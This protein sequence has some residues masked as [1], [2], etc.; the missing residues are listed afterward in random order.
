V[1]LQGAP[2]GTAYFIEDITAQKR[3]EANLVSTR[4]LADL[5]TLT[6]G[7]V[8]ELKSP[9]QVITGQSESLLNRLKRGEP[10]DAERLTRGLEM[11]N[12]NGWRIADTIRSMLDYARTSS[13]PMEPSNLN[14]L[15]RD[16]LLLVEHEL[17]TRANI[18]I[19]TDL[20]PDLPVWPC[21]RNQIIQALIN[22]LM[23]AQDAMSAG[24]EIIIRT[25]YFPERRR[26][27]L[28]VADTGAGI[29]EGVRE[30]I[31]SPFFTTKPPGV[32]TG[33]GLSILMSIVQ[34]H[35]GEVSVESRTI[36]PDRGTTFTLSFPLERPA[37]Q[38][39][40]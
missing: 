24:G 13:A 23:N 19:H 17:A 28:A 34:A 21:D 38:A 27:L 36:P 1:T 30:K 25:H 31:F 37:A 5:G 3:L 15:V 16:T 33:L 39:S 10:P 29:S 12:R 32:G 8:H 4:K 40:D 22:L 2:G 35:G 26:L 18:Q 9:L 6:A 11:I 7:I 14:D 20:A